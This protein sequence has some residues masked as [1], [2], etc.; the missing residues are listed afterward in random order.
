MTCTTIGVAVLAL[1][2][3]VSAT[4]RVH[5]L[6]ACDGKRNVIYHFYGRS[7]QEEVV[8]PVEFTKQLQ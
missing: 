8:C 6:T 3:F 7:T 5:V 4:K 1:L 2:M